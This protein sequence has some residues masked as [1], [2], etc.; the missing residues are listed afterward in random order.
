MFNIDEQTLIE[1]SKKHCE[2]FLQKEQRSLATFTG[3]PSLMYI[4]DPRL[5]RFLLDPSKGVLYL[6][7]QSFLDRELDDNQIMWHIYYELALYP[8]WKKQ[9]KKYLN[10]KKDWQKEIDHITRYI[11]ARIKKEGLEKDIAYQPKI[12]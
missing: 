4:P 5:E 2:E 8:D 11:L 9:T 1:E 6:P 10:R 12:I 3:D 7:L